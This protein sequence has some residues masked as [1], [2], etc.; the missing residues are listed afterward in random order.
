MKVNG[1]HDATSAEKGDEKKCVKRK[2]VIVIDFIGTRRL[3]FFNKHTMGYSCIQKP[4]AMRKPLD[5]IELS[6]AKANMG[7]QNHTSMSHWHSLPFS[8]SST[9][10][11]SCQAGPIW[12]VSWPDDSLRSGS[13]R[14]KEIC[15]GHSEGRP[16][17]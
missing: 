10:S 16:F 15:G 2:M 12:E 5:S 11:P 14:G 7:P 4:V 17:D 6:I 9:T 13:R 1:I 3:P 8:L